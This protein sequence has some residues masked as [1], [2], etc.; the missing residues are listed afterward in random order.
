MENQEILRRYEP[1]QYHTYAELTDLL[2]SFAA[3]Y[4]DLCRVRSI[5]RS[6]ENRE[7]WAVELGSG[8]LDEKP[9]YYI[10][11]NLHASEV[12]GCATALYIIHTLLTGYGSDPE[13]TRLLDELAFY[14][15]PRICVDGAEACLV[16]GAGPYNLRSSV[17]L[18]PEPEPQPGLHPEDVNG[19]GH[20]LLMRWQAE[21]GEWKVSDLDARL[22]I[23]REPHERSGTFYKL[24]WEGTVKGFNGVEIKAA[25]NKWG[26]DLNRNWPANWEPQVRQAGAGP[27]PLSEP[28]TRAVAEYLLSKQ[29]VFGVQSF[30]TTT[31]I[32]LR[33][34]TQKADTQMNQKDLAAFK[35]IGAVGERYT[36]YPC[37]SSFEGFSKGTPIKGGFVD[38][39]YEHL[40]LTVFLTELWDALARS[41]SERVTLKASMEVAG[42]N[43]LRWNDRELSGEGF[44]NWTPFDHPQ[45]GKVEIGGWKTMF[46]L[47]N[48]PHHLLH[49]EVHKSMRFTLA[50]AD[51]APRLAVTDLTAT[52]LEDGYVRISAVVRNTGYLPT[53]VTEQAKAM[54][55]AKPVTVEISLPEGATLVSG[56]ARQEIGDLQGWINTG[57]YVFAAPDPFRKEK[58]MEWVV[59]ATRPGT[60]TVTARSPRAGKGTGRVEISL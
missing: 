34:S 13:A 9:G 28:E 57:Y 46:T 53:Y 6:F 52:A 2:H 10:D 22:M 36:G 54:G 50:H 12:T 5:G 32:I 26:L 60:C 20:T 40:G 29:N 43:L 35:A 27:Y 33:P 39:C 49:Q 38:W 44:V 8:N 48:P 7:I 15:I 19:D 4:P 1:N 31:G 51:S 42:L 23:P 47:K 17:K 18:W 24:T 58:R 16:D 45:L 11:G 59:R 21:D 30:H 55:Q 41:G 25:P 14:I 3:L 56:Q 37:V